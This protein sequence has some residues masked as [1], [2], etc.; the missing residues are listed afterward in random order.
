M[1]RLTT[2]GAI[3]LRDRL[4]RP[5]REVLSQPKRIALL[6]HLVLEGRRGPVARD[7]LCAMFWPESD[8]TRAR[9]ALSQAVYHLRQSIGPDL[10]VGQGP[11]LELAADQVWC[12]ALVFRLNVTAIFEVA[13]T[14]LKNRPR[15]LHG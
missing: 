5:V 1:L 15:I 12:D 4:G 10:L 2:L 11:T 14:L 13:V 7:R 6:I 9:N 3:D 8:E